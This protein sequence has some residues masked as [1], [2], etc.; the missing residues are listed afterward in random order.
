MFEREVVMLLKYETNWD[1][2]VFRVTSVMSEGRRE[3]GNAKYARVS[4]PRLV[5]RNHI[6]ARKLWRFFVVGPLVSSRGLVRVLY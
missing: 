2:N 5:C 4:Y 1:A 3:E 6:A